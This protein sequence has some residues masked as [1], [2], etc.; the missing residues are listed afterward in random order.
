LT[1]K[2]QHEPFGSSQHLSASATH[3]HLVPAHG[4]ELVDLYVSPERG[5]ELKAGS[6]DFPSWDLT[7]RQTCDLELL[8]SGAFS[9]LRG[10]M[11]EA[12]YEGVCRNMRLTTGIL[13]PMPVVLDVSEAFAKTL[14]RKTGKIALRDGEGVMLAVLHVDDVWHP[15]RKSEAEAVFRT[16]STLHPGVDYLLNKANPWYVGGRI[17]GLQAPS[18]YDFKSLRLTP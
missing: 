12:E 9:P 15:D 4:G 1:M 16:T 6:K 8:L 17:E 10:F 14:K 7:V 2:Q 11:T 13:W 5:A 3:S 18:N